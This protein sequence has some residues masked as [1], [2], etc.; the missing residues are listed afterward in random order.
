MQTQ[1]K[2]SDF[3]I[4]PIM[5]SVRKEEISDEIYFSNQYQFILI[6]N[7]LFNHAGWILTDEGSS[8]RLMKNKGLIK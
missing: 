6:A 1:I 8:A 3:E 5:K 7:K 2:F 4:I